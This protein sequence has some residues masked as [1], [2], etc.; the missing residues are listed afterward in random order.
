MADQEPL[1]SAEQIAVPDALPQILK[2]W[3]KEVIRASPQDIIAFSADY[4]ARKLE[5]RKAATG[6]AKAGAGGH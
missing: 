2:D 5:E 3:T 4:F 1:Y 6:G